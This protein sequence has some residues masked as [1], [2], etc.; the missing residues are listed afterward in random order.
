MSLSIICA[1][2][3]RTGTTSLKLVLEQLGFAPCYKWIEAC[4][5]APL[6]LDAFEHKPVDWEKMFGPFRSVLDFPA[7][8]FY[9]E[10]IAEFPCSKVILTVRDSNSWFASAQATYLSPLQLRGLRQMSIWPLQERMLSAAFGS[11]LHDRRSVIAHYEQHNIEVR[12]AV[13]ADRLLVYEMHRGWA[14]LCKFLG[15]PIPETPFPHLNTREEWKTFER[16]PV[17]K[18]PSVVHR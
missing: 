16:R 15:V 1:G 17:P 18:R 8:L 14:S 13:P 9:R 11:K 3:G 12:K 4:R 6:W 10:L 7:C 2:Y 5:S